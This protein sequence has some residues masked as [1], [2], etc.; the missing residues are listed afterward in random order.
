MRASGHHVPGLA[1][2]ARAVGRQRSPECGLAKLTSTHGGAI[3]PSMKSGSAGAERRDALRPRAVARPRVLPGRIASGF[4][5]G[6]PVTVAIGAGG[7]R[8]WCRTTGVA[9]YSSVSDVDVVVV[10][11]QLKFQRSSGHGSYP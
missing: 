10:V 5:L 9:S 3:G 2:G 8:I 6:V 4:G 11:A 7:R 1:S